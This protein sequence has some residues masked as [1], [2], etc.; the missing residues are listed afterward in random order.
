M[1]LKL[2][3]KYN[4]M[5]VLAKANI[6]PGNKYMPQDILNGI[7]KVLNI[8]AQIMCVTDKTTK[9]SYVFEIR[10]CFD[11]TLQLVNCDGIYDFPTNCDRT[12]TLTYPS[13][14]PRY[15]VTQL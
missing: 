2:L 13:R 15:H 3:D 7:Q 14:V 9:E 8:R 10:I 12:K 1:G 6:S 5:D 4:M 11:K